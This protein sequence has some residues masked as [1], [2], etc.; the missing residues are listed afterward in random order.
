MGKKT[1]FA[2][3]VAVLAVALGGAD[4]GRAAQQPVRI[5][6]VRPASA[7]TASLPRGL[8]ADRLGSRSA[9][10]GVTTPRDDGAEVSA[11]LSRRAYGA[12]QYGDLKVALYEMPD[13]STAFAMLRFLRPTD[14]ATGAIADD[15]WVSDRASAIR[16]GNFAVVVEG[17]DAA[18]R[19][20][21]AAALVERIGRP[22]PSAPLL[23]ELPAGQIEGSARY[24]P[25]FETLRRLRPDLAE[26]VYRFGAGGADAAVADYAQPGAEPFR[27]VLVDYQTP[28]LAADAERSLVAYFEALPPEVRERRI[29]RREGNYMLEATGVTDRAAAERVLGGVKYS[30]AI[31]MLQGQNPFDGLDLNTETYKAAMIFVNSFTLVGLGFLAAVAC[32]LVVG[33]IVFRRRK[34]AAA[35]MFSDAGGMTHLDIRGIAKKLPSAGAA[36]GFLSSGRAD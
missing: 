4:I 23:E 30:F 19:E 21:I 16:V 8:L 2:I 28:Q 35:N 22:A 7:E 36:R 33:T 9:S 13:E 20:E 29:L 26:D 32:G 10:S 17:A 3:A 15:S 27:L 34:L 5:T 1:T 24:A 6:T 11:Q 14:A 18:S 12:R 25:S 31:K